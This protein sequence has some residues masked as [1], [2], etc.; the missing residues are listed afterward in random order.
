MIPYRL[1]R[2]YDRDNGVMGDL[3]R[4]DELLCFTLEHPTLKIPEGTYKLEW[5][6]S[7]RFGLFTPRLMDVPGHEGILIH[8]GNTIADTTGCILVGTG[9]SMGKARQAFLTSSRPARDRVYELMEHDLHD[10][11]AEIEIRK[12]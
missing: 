4:M 10:G 7:P 8:A 9:W 11:F 5:T 1:D 2:W 3:Y 12:V 6:I